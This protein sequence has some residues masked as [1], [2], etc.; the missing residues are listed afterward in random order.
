MRKFSHLLRTESRKRWDI[1]KYLLVNL[2]GSDA[3]SPTRVG[4]F[5]GKIGRER[6]NRTYYGKALKRGT[7]YDLVLSSRFLSSWRTSTCSVPDSLN[8][9][10]TTG[11]VDMYLP[12]LHFA[13]W[14]GAPM[15]TRSASIAGLR[16]ASPCTLLCLPHPVKMLHKRN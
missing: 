14:K 8:Q 7:L 2:Q 6:A 16:V 5:Q 11:P 15:P 13:N 12:I 1:T 9:A 4:T 3:L 10:A